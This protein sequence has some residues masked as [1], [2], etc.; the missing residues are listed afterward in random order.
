VPG[1]GSVRNGCVAPFE[2]RVV[3]RHRAAVASAAFGGEGAGSGGGRSG[4]KS[5]STK[6]T[7]IDVAVDL[8]APAPRLLK[9]SEAA[10]GASSTSLGSVGSIGNI[11]GGEVSTGVALLDALLEEFRAACGF[12]FKVACTGDTYID[13]HHTAE[14][15]SITLGQCLLA[16]LGDKAGLARMGCAEAEAAAPEAPPAG[17]A[18]AFVATAASSATGGESGSSVGTARVRVVIDLS[19]RPHFES[20]LEEHLD[21]EFV[22]GQPARHAAAAAAGGGGGEEGGDGVVC[23][24]AL[25]SEMLVHVFESLTLEMRA[26]GH[27]QVLQSGAASPSSAPVEG[28]TLNVALAMARAY[29]AALAE[30]VRVDPRRAGKVASSKGTLSV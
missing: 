22:G 28:H 7:S 26:T 1:R 29:G 23:G 13:D 19:N 14:D 5:R 11:G 8:D 17:A 2:D 6:E 24:R 16:G 12:D 10:N 27:V 25:T 30:C 3:A 18:S 4:A 15:V 9:A 20:N 21:E